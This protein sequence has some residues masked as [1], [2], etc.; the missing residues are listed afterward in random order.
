MPPFGSPETR[1][2]DYEA[3]QAGVAGGGRRERERGFTA[4]V[5]CI[6]PPG[7]GVVVWKGGEAQIEL[8]GACD[9][10]EKGTPVL[11]RDLTR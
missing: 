4:Y 7:K 8:L 11:R 1:S 3:Q 2:P 5:H 9:S 6:Y 10:G